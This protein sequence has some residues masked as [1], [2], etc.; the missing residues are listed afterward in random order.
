MY[1][2]KA[3]DESYDNQYGIFILGM[4]EMRPLFVSQD[5]LL[6]DKITDMLNTSYDIGYKH[7]AELGYE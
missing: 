5:L 3:Y 1:L 6:I 4:E 7:G 2:Y